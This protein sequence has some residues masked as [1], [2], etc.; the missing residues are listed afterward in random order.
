MGRNPFSPMPNIS[1]PDIDTEVIDQ[2]DI[3]ITGKHTIIVWNDDVNTFQNVI[4]ALIDICEHEPHQ[5]EQCALM[6]HFKG[7]CGVKNGDFET[8]RPKAEGL[9]DRGINA[10]IE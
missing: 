4:E 1:S 7:K 10:T 2:E 6:V 5:A 9:I 3:G 8:L